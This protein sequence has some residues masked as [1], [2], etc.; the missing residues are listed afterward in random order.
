MFS[1]PPLLS[2]QPQLYIGDLDSSTRECDLFSLLKPYGEVSMIRLLKSSSP[3]Q[4]S[5]AFISFK[6]PSNSSKI[7][8]ELNGS[9]LGS[10]PMRVCRV[11]KDIDPQANIFI[12]NI[13]S[14]ATFQSL[15]E[16]FDPFGSIVS[17]KIAFNSQGS[18]LGYGFVQ[19]EKRSQAEKAI[20]EMNGFVWEDRHL[21]VCEYLPI[22]ARAFSNK[23]N[24]Y[25]KNFPLSY[26]QED[27]KRIFE[28]FGD[29]VSVAVASSQQR[30][31]PKAFGFV[32]FQDEDSAQKACQEMH[33]FK[34][35][36]FEWYV[37]P[38]M[39]RV[40]RQAF[41]KE[42]YQRQIEDWKMRNLYIRN[43]HQ[44][45]CENKIKD[46]FGGFGEITSI[47]IVRAEHIKYNA[48]GD[49]SRVLISNGVG[50]VC[51]LRPQDSA[52]ALMEIH[53]KMIEGLK[54]FVARWRPRKELRANLLARGNQR[55][56]QPFNNSINSSENLPNPFP[57]RSQ[58]NPF[59]RFPLPLLL[60][61]LPFHQTREELGE[62]IYPHVVH[63]SN[64]VIAGKIT[65]M[66]IDLGIPV[67]SRLLQDPSALKEKIFE[68][69]SVLRKAWENNPSQLR[70]LPN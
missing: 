19:F 33:G 52:K 10:S 22:T 28:K 12:K 8:R 57:I 48:D 20:K 46:L 37:A 13:P 9:K 69:I 56:R 50:F 64:D 2:T 60:R 16:K 42:Q 41:L 26:T 47:K 55:Q 15:D 58:L 30:E 27:V 18:P 35:E 31:G 21:V 68:A 53:G 65:G 39:T 59:R 3:S 63:H 49:M 5:F 34:E 51:F 44:S 17:S 54:I 61:P 32:C 6:D 24:L 45:I 7:R 14:N 4:K 66:L 29:V 67:A 43:L 11:T 25:I 38:H 36:T 62:K 1:L 40:A 70:L 23:H